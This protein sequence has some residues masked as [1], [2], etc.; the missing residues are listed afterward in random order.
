[1]GERGDTFGAFVAGFDLRVALHV[2]TDADS[3][4]AAPGSA[5]AHGGRPSRGTRTNTSLV[6]QLSNLEASVFFSVLTTVR[7]GRVHVAPGDPCSRMSRRRADGH[8][9][10]DTLAHQDPLP[11]SPHPPAN[12]T[13]L[14]HELC[15]P[16]RRLAA[17]QA[18]WDSP[19]A[20]APKP[21]SSAA[22]SLRSRGG[23]VKGAF[24]SAAGLANLAV[25][26]R[27]VLFWSLPGVQ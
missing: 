19:R 21:T 20:Q 25:L 2:T 10:R 23:H 8:S 13:P 4:A 15:H 7:T 14:G 3:D 5:W 9:E 11:D 1:M 27:Q 16:P 18:L 22:P 26:D 17:L 12:S 6:P 24:S